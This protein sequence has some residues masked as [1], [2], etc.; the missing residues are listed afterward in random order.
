LDTYDLVLKNGRVIDPESGTDAVLNVGVSGGSV[1]A[2]SE[3]TMRS[4]EEL[5]ASGL[6]V[7]PGFID[8]HSHGQDDE[9]Y[10]IQAQDGV[11]TALE[12]EVGTADVDAWYAAREGR[13]LI[14][15]GASA[16]HIPTRMKV[17]RDPGT[18]L[19]VGDAAHRRSTD[20]E[21]A[22]I[23]RILERGLERGAIAVGFGLQYTP[24][25]SG[26]EVFE[27]FRIAA[28]F[29]ASCHVHVRGMGHAEPIGGVEGVE[30][31]IAASAVTGAPLH[32]V[33][34]SSSG[35][36]ATERL[37]QIVGEAQKRGMDVTTECYPYGAGMSGIE[38]AIFD[39]GWKKKL[40]VS[41][42]DLLWPAT[43]ERLTAESFARYREQR[44]MVIVHFIPDAALRAAV[45]SPLTAIATDGYLRGGVGHP[46]TAGSYAR[47]L[48][49]FVRG[50]KSLTLME[51][52]RKSALMPAK[53][54]EKRTPR[55]RNKGRIRVGADADLAA[56]DPKTVEDRAT[57]Q[58]P[59]LPSAGFRHVLVGGVPV[60]RDGKLQQGVAPGKPVRA[61]F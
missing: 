54:L 47:V 37:L 6:V 8:L 16:G 52:I 19:P 13:A 3:K 7:A 24:A 25:A 61:P 29:G 5:D 15:Y 20:G 51:A 42:G 32:V 17:L 4:K 12:L 55:M 10:R 26:W 41:Y 48:G 56:F 57:Y 44:G 49:R 35:L 27:A 14:N 45:T 21:T 50:S 22:E 36:A 39:E 58:Q 38:S 23:L 46:R 18:F 34:I 43:G 59:T 40:G 28:R 11:T 33:H 30:E 9:N 60:V 2:L 1:Q 31:V 53:R